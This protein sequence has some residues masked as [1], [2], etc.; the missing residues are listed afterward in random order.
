MSSLDFFLKFIYKQYLK[1]VLF[2]YLILIFIRQ[3][4]FPINSFYIVFLSFSLVLFNQIG[5]LP[6]VLTI[7]NISKKSVLQLFWYTSFASLTIL[8]GIL[9]IEF[10]FFKNYIPIH[11]SI[12]IFLLILFIGNYISVSKFSFFGI[13][14]NLPIGT[15]CL[16]LL[17]YSLIFELFSLWY[18]PVLLI[19]Y[20]LYFKYQKYMQLLLNVSKYYLYEKDVAIIKNM[21][22]D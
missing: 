19:S 13:L 9:L 22:N 2:L 3:W 4:I 14:F 20:F 12:I 1:N 18:I 10:V 16:Y 15:M 5:V 6:G 11:K 21:K 17:I 8:I 7:L